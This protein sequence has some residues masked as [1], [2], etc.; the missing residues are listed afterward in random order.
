[1]GLLAAF[2]IA[3]STACTWDNA[4]HLFLSRRLKGESG[5]DKNAHSTYYEVRHVILVRSTV[6]VQGTDPF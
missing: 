2:Q 3:D 6:I 5:V 4:G 1:M